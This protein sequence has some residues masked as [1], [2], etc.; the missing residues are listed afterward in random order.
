MEG[1]TSG[2]S[3]PESNEV[4]WRGWMRTGGA[5]IAGGGAT[6]LVASVLVIVG[7]ISIF[8]VDVTDPQSL[9]TN[10]VASM[11]AFLVSLVV[12]PIA[13]FLAG[14]GLFIFESGTPALH[15]T[16]MSGRP[17]GVSPATRAKARTAGALIIL[18]G[19]LGVVST[20]ILA[21]LMFGS[22]S[23]SDVVALFE[24]ILVVWILA[25]V[26][27][28]VAAGMYS[29]FFRKVSA[30][31]A[32]L[33]A[34][35]GTALLVYAIM[36]VIGVFLL[37][38]PLV[39]VFADPSSAPIGLVIPMLIGGLME[40]LVMPVVG[41][42]TFGF[43]AA[44]GA[45]IREIRAGSQPMVPFYAAVPLA[46]AYVMPYAAPYYPSPPPPYA[47]P[48]PAPVAQ[49][50]PPPLAPTLQGAAADSAAQVESRIAE[51]ENALTEQ[52]GLLMGAER[53]LIEGRIDN[54]TYGDIAR[55]REE[56]IAELRKEIDGLKARSPPPPPSSEGV[57]T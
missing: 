42:I 56:R 57:S 47:P 14:A 43:M 12:I 49:M 38:I 39:W 45:R 53:G 34:A 29:S 26:V 21:L 9:V 48:P 28:V 10:A 20:V 8:S 54:A 17:R 36:N 46:P 33:E 11:T 15:W 51:L 1:N 23:A 41:M 22:G 13:A 16:D 3:T 19:F 37:A 4:Q 55:R 6:W 40:L 27:L 25:S 2:I 18:Y 31:S 52:K 7:L 24:A 44:H 35:G 32:S 50:P 5:L 30:E